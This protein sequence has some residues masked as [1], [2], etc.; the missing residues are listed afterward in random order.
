MGKSL[1]KKGKCVN[2]ANYKKKYIKNK[3]KTSCFCAFVG[4]VWGSWNNNENLQLYK[5]VINNGNEFMDEHD[6]ENMCE[7]FEDSLNIII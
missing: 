2:K 5:Y 4:A 7:N 6:H 1:C 3:P